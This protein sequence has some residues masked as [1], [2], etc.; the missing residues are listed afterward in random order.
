MKK[1]IACLALL[2]GLTGFAVTSDASPAAATGSCW[3][4][5]LYWTGSTYGNAGYCSV[6]PGGNWHVRGWIQC[7]GVNHYGAWTNIVNARSW[8]YCPVGTGVTAYGYQEQNF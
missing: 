8:A 1:I 3:A 5:G 7:N 2:L 4:S 6:S